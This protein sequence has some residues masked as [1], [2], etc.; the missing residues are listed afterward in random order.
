MPFYERSTHTKVGPLMDEEKEEL[1]KS[2][3]KARRKELG[4][5]VIKQMLK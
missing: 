2:I 1:V 5:P 4:S 3:L